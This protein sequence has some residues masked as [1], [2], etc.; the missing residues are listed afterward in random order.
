MWLKLQGYNIKRMDSTNE[1]RQIRVRGA[2]G[3]TALVRVVEETLDTYYVTSEAEYQK[4]HRA[5]EKVEARIGFP[6]TD[7]IAV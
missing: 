1:L 6:K 7:A 2:G 5:G 3:Q 4:A